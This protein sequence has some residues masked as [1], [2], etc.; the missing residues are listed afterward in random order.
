MINKASRPEREDMSNG[1]DIGS[2]LANMDFER[3]ERGYDYGEDE[4]DEE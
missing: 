2:D 4:E 3:K 1:E